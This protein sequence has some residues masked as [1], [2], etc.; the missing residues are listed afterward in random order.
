MTVVAIHQP[1]YLP[2]VPYCAKAAL[3]DV[4]VYLDTVQF[5]KNGVQ[6]RNQIKTPQGAQWLTVPV[7]ASLQCSIREI[8]V[9]DQRW[10]KKHIQSIQQNYTRAPLVEWFMQDL[11]PILEKEWKYLADLNIAVTEWLF[12]RLGIACKRL[13]ASELNAAGSKDDLVISICREVGATAYLSGQGAK[14]YQ[15]DNKFKEQGI[16]LRYQIYQN[17]EYPQCH[18]AIGF[19]KDLSALDLILNTGRQARDFMLAGIDRQ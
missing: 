19:C 3:C 15:D 4:F 17:Q 9:A 7:N 5:Q 16:D 13:R 12:S 11:R 1:Q 2:W 10:Q 18:S 6:N 14:I 8:C